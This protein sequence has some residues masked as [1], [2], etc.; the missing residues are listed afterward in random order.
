[1]GGPLARCYRRLVSALFS[2]REGRNEAV[3]NAGKDRGHHL[4]FPLSESS[5]VKN[6]HGYVCA[7][8]VLPS[9]TRQDSSKEEDLLIQ[10]I[11]G[12]AIAVQ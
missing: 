8:V 6:E 9:V 1:M 3:H 10:K 11:D 12:V 7:K 2:R 5:P 4:V